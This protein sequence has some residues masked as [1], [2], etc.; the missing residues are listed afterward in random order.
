MTAEWFR[1]RKKLIAAVDLAMQRSEEARRE[2]NVMK[3]N[4]HEHMKRCDHRYPDGSC[5]ICYKT[6]P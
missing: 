6:D 2:E 4:L 3:I 1:R 5:R